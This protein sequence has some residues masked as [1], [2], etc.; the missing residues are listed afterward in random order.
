MVDLRNVSLE[1][2]FNGQEE[3]PGSQRAYDRDREIT[4]RQFRLASELAAVQ[5]RA[6]EKQI[7]AAEAVVSKPLGSVDRPS[8][9]LSPRPSQC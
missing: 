7:L 1:D 6:A 4:R 3:Q 9:S 8:L 2:L 5:T